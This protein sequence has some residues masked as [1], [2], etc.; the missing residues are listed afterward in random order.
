MLHWL[1]PGLVLRGRSGL[2]SQ[3]FCASTTSITGALTTWAVRAARTMKEGWKKP[4]EAMQG[5]PF[6]ARSEPLRP[7]RSPEREILQ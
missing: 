7:K 5:E 6:V 2:R 4:P 1:R 3:I